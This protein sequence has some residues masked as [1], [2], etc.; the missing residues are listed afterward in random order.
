[1]SKMRLPSERSTVQTDRSNNDIISDKWTQLYE[2]IACIKSGFI[3]LKNFVLEEIR[4]MKR[5]E[6][7]GM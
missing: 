7:T 5:F 4:D 3:C 6:G 2:D 1:M